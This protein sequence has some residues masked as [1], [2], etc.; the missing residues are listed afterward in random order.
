M[1]RF[2]GGFQ[3]G[4]M[5]LQR[6]QGQIRPLPP[7]FNASQ[8]S[9]ACRSQCGELSEASQDYPHLPSASQSSDANCADP[10]AQRQGA[11]HAIPALTGRA[12][13]DDTCLADACGAVPASQISTGPLKDRLSR[14]GA[15]ATLPHLEHGLAA[16]CQNSSQDTRQRSE[17]YSEGPSRPKVNAAEGGEAMEVDTL[18][19]GVSRLT[20]TASDGAVPATFSFGRR[21]GRG[22]LTGRTN[23]SQ[24]KTRPQTSGGE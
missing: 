15:D 12:A 13:Q 4:S 10:G 9:Q 18:V 1:V 21:R 11:Q 19:T 23:A 5:H 8:H 3:Y 7:P 14:D 16:T 6:H 17:S 22:R 24:R 20:M 2:P